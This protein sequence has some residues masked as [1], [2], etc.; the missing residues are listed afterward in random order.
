MQTNG[1]QPLKTMDMQIKMSTAKNACHSEMETI[2]YPRSPPAR[3]WMHLQPQGKM[4]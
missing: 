4:A 2:S 3:T 1:L